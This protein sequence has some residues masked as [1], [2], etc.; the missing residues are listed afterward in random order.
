MSLSSAFK[1]AISS[2]KLLSQ[3][4]RNCPVFASTKIAEPI[5]MTRRFAVSKAAIQPS[6]QFRL[7]LWQLCALSLRE[8][9]LPDL[10]GP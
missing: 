10:Y 3:S 2:P 7:W 5:F 1:V 4:S 6:L 8:R 9:L